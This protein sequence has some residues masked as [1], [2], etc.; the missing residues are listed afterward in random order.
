[1]SNNGLKIIATF[2]RHEDRITVDGKKTD[3]IT[4]EAKER[5][6][7]Y[8]SWISR[9]YSN[10]DHDVLRLSANHSKAERS[11]ETA[12]HVL[13]GHFHSPCFDQDLSYSPHLDPMNLGANPE[14]QKEMEAQ[15]DYD[16]MINFLLKNP[17]P[18]NLVQT[19]EECGQRTLEQIRECLKQQG[20]SGGQYRELSYIENIGHGPVLEAGLVQLVEPGLKDIRVLHGGLRQGEAFRIEYDGANATLYFR[21]ESLNIHNL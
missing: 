9:R 17:D 2:R 15:G 7:V 16:A 21:G 14:Y 6:H 18:K 11:K 1:M 8:G 19:M 13:F 3:H 20:S 4:D 5:C 12:Y 10:A